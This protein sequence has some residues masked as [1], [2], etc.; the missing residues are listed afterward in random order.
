MRSPVQVGSINDRATAVIAD[1]SLGFGSPMEVILSV[2]Y[3]L[4]TPPGFPTRPQFTGSARPGNP[5]ILPAG[6][7]VVLHEP[8]AR[9]LLAAGAARLDLSRGS[10]ATRDGW[11]LPISEIAAEIADA[12]VSETRD[13]SSNLSRAIAGHLK[14]TA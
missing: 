13:G 7:C 9:A 1:L 11:A 4:E 6:T 5:S 3:A 8:E 2:D 14:V 12:I 10:L